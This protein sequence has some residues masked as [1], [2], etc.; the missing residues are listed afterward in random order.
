VH[1][2]RDI[3]KVLGDGLAN[4]VSLLIGGILQ[5]FLAEVITERIWENRQEEFDGQIYI[6][7]YQS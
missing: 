5:Q 6:F 2:E 7:A 3:N 4:N 1:I